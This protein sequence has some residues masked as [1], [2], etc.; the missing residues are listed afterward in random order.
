MR[1]AFLGDTHGNWGH[2]KRFYEYL[3]VTD[4][5]DDIDAVVQVG[6]FGFW[7]HKQHGVEFLDCVDRIAANRGVPLYWIDGNHENFE[8]LYENY[9]QEKWDEF[10]P[11]RDNVIYIPRG[12]TWEWDG[13]KFMAF[14]GAYSVDKS[15]R[16]PYISWW[17]HETP[18]MVEVDRAAANGTV[19]V[20]ITHDVCHLSNINLVMG[21]SRIDA[22]EASRDML[23]IVAAN[24]R[25][26]IIIHGHYHYPIRQI[27]GAPWGDVDI[28]GLD[29]DYTAQK[30]GDVFDILD[31]ADYA[32]PPKETDHVQ[33]QREAT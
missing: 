17:P 23:D 16:T 13:V 6:D 29:S 11:I 4:L 27:V 19:D 2:I 32:A 12:K 24:A 25:P 22:C 28:I 3:S 21:L 9:V 8:L 15:A 20:L 5:L 26:R 30:W 14:G 1:I 33:D 18:T 31:T 10:I 7:E